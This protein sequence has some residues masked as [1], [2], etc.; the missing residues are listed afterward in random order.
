MGDVT[1][2]V[3]CFFIPPCFWISFQVINHKSPTT[4][5]TDQV[6]L[7]KLFKDVPPSVP[8]PA[9]AVER[10]GHDSEPFR[11]AFQGVEDDHLPWRS[12]IDLS[13]L[14]LW[15]CQF[16]GFLVNPCYVPFDSSETKRRLG[17]TLDVF[18]TPATQS[19]NQVCHSG[20]GL[21]GNQGWINSTSLFCWL[22]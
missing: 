5:P 17:K 6:D 8:A 18:R 9:P 3:A 20:A 4:P 19:F 15:D 2:S 22:D 11:S 13:R 21:D 1:T 7:L 14:R 10:S 12:I 16:H